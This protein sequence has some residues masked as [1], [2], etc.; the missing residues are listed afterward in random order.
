MDHIMITIVKK[1]Y[2]NIKSL[3]DEVIRFIPNLENPIEIINQ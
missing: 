3:Y 1:I 2:K